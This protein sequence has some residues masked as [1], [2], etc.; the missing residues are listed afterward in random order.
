MSDDKAFL[1]QL[2]LSLAH[3]LEWPFGQIMDRFLLLNRALAINWCGI[4]E[5]YLVSSYLVRHQNVAFRVSVLL[6]WG[7]RKLYQWGWRWSRKGGWC[8]SRQHAAVNQVIHIVGNHRRRPTYRREHFYFTDAITGFQKGS[9]S[10]G[11]TNKLCQKHWQVSI[12]YCIQFRRA[13]K[14]AL[15]VTPG[16]YLL[17][18]FPLSSQITT[19]SGPSWWRILWLNVNL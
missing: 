6:G 18:T 10:P 2:R 15:V 9:G 16:R 19:Q 4:P 13:M 14:Q 1:L 17:W 12:N 3:S 8:G 7:W 5:R 11:T